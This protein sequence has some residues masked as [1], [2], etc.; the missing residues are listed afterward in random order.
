MVH[1]LLM[2]PAMA[3]HA[4]LLTNADRQAHASCGQ[5]IVLVRQ[6]A[7]QTLS[8]SHCDAV[9]MIFRHALRKMRRDR[10]IYGMNS[11]THP[12][13]PAQHIRQNARRRTAGRR[14]VLTATPLP[15]R[16]LVWI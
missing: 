8:N 12:P 14:Q 7:S 1:L 15:S 16:L 13:A 3:S 2:Q 9:A 10:W 4:A 11:W 6:L 5:F